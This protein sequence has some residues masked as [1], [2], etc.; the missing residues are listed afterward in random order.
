MRRLMRSSLTTL[1]GDGQPAPEQPV[2]WTNDYLI[3]LAQALTT[4]AG[5]GALVAVAWYWIARGDLPVHAW[6]VAA[7]VA[8]V[9]CVMWTILRYHGDEIGLYRAAYRAG[10]RSRDAEVNGLQLELDIALDA[11]E[12]AVAGVSSTANARINRL[13]VARENAP[14]LLRVIY[15]PS[16]GPAHATR[17]Q[18]EL[19]K[20]MRQR[21][22]ERARELSI[23]AGVIDNEMQPLYP[24]YRAAVARIEEVYQTTVEAMRTRRTFGV[25]WG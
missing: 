18:M 19:T 11:T 3:Q 14:I 8:L 21:T 13:A 10:Q 17:R 25:P 6:A 4:G 15:D 12:N 7:T 24:N 23:K 2:S 22:W 5:V 16:Q 9:W 20:G 1:D